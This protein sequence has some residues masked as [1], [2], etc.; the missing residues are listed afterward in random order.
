MG[1]AL[2]LIDIQNDYFPGGKMEVSGSVE[3]SLRAREVL[4][5]FRE[6][7]MP[8][9][10]VR[11]VSVRAGASFFLPGTQG[12]EIHPNVKPLSS[13]VVVEKNYPNSFRDTLLRAVLEKEGITRLV[14]AGM[15]THMCVDATTRAAF[16]YGFGCTVLHDACATRQ[17]SFRGETVPAGQVQSAFLAAL[18][19]VYAMVLPTAEFI[20]GETAN[21][22]EKP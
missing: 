5:F 1:K 22:D 7:Q 15:M 2:L 14:V 17:L 21:K 18:N 19:G 4:D 3:A 10:H 12:A 6:K 11:H 9:F 16:D 13:E 8:V 20:S